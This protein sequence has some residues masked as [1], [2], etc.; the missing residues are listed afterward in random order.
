MILIGIG[1]NMGDREFN[2]ENALRILSTDC[3][4]QIKKISAIYETAPYGNVD[5]SDFL[6]QVA[7]IE[8]D[9]F[10]HE[11]LECCL[12]IERKM[13]RIREIRW[14]PRTIDIDILW[15]KGLSVDE[16]DLQIPHPGNSKR[17]FILIPMNE[18]VPDLKL[19]NGL[20]AGELLNEVDGTQRVRLW[21]KVAWNDSQKH[22]EKGPS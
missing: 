17:R 4:V 2:I 14:G 8:T 5:Q 10:P 1:S 12:S 16:E 6:N 21:K 15:W 13:G 3:P 19:H 7:V 18:I 20:T 9:L 11:L 22:F